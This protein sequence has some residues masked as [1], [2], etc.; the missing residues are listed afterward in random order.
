MIQ[1]KLFTIDFDCVSS[2][3]LWDI[4]SA[5]AFEG[6]E[7]IVTPNVDHVIRLLEDNL[8]EIRPIY[9]QA[10]Y[11]VCDSRILYWMAKALGREIP[12][13]VTGSDFTALMFERLAGTDVSI[14]IIG[15]SESCVQ[16]LKN[17]YNLIQV[18]HYNPPMG[19]VNDEEEI[20]KCVEFIK[21]AESKFVFFAVGS[22]QQE[23]LARRVKLSGAKGTGF[24]VGA[25]LLFL[26]GEEKRAP[27]WINMMGFEWFYRFLQNPKKLAH[28]Y[29]I[30]DTKIFKYFLR[31]LADKQ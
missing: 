20:L 30:Q 13:V 22:P 29:F 16:A 9:D 27:K 12:H 21:H 8:N 3:E 15:A 4:V 31:A 7:Y 11:R 2:E 6:F 24:C 5:R 26:S 18:K 10:L 14:S 25:S 17:K 23:V 1:R 28:R 19:F